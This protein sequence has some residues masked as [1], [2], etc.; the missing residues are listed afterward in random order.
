V[1]ALPIEYGACVTTLNLSSSPITDLKVDALVVGADVVEG[2]PRLAPGSEPV[3]AAL[4]RTARADARELGCTG[5]AGEAVRLADVRR[6]HRAGGR[7]G[8]AG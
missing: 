4:G 1:R 6:D 8:R 5:A 7:R 3:D 2:R